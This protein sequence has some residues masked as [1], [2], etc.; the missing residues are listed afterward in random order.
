[1]T[2]NLR[3]AQFDQLSR[4][5]LIEVYTLYLEELS[6]YDK[7]TYQRLPDGSWLPDLLPYWLS[8]SFAHPLVAWLDEMPCGFSLVGVTPFPYKS[9]NVDARISEFWVDSRFRRKGIGRRCAEAVFKSFE[10]VWEVT[11]VE[12]NHIAI[13]FWVD[14]IGRFTSGSFDNIKEDG[15]HRQ[16]FRS[17]G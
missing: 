7:D 4:N 8:K 9:P 2:I 12:S 13:R 15:E 6:Q 1:M 17:L 5:W 10:G 3:N 11:E 16:V 14:V